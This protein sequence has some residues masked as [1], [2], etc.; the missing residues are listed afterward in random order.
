MGAWIE[1]TNLGTNVNRKVVAPY[2]GA[3]I[4]IMTIV[5]IKNMTSYDVPLVKTKTFSFLVNQIF[6]IEMYNNSTLWN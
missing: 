4:E 1:I 2:M 5:S 6:P 3:W